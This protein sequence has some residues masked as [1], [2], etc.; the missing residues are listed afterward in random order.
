VELRVNSHSR[1]LTPR[2][3]AGLIVAAGS[4]SRNAGFKRGNAIE[5]LLLKGRLGEDQKGNQGKHC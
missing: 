4:Q 2:E 3:E 1:W 5:E